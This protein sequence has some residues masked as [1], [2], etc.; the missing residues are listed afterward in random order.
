ME[1]G[2]NI[3]CGE[4]LVVHKEE[5]DILDV[6]DQEGL[7]AGWHHVAGLL[8]CSETNLYI[9]ISFASFGPTP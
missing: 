4:G 7:V 3:L 9:P 6:V 5:V 8:V 1:G 2:K